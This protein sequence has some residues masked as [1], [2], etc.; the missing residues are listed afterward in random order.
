MDAGDEFVVGVM[1]AKLVEHRGCTGDAQ[2]PDQR[3][4]TLEFGAICLRGLSYEDD[5]VGES[6]GKFS[7]RRGKER[8]SVD[9]EEVRVVLDG[10]H[11]QHDEVFV[12]RSCGWR[13]GWIGVAGFEEAGG[14][15][16]VLDQFRGLEGCY[17]VAQA[18]HLASQR[19]NEI[20]DL[21]G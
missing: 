20:S 15:F 18:P 12:R 16:A 1:Q 2:A 3:E 7:F 11:L 13:D 9:E 8:K 21:G 5:N 10:F 14:E 19:G 17:A 6:C 4:G